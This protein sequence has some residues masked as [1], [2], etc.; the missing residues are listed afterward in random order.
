YERLFA[1]E[2]PGAAEDVK[3]ELNPS[4]L[5]TVAGF[6]EPGLRDAPAGKSLQFERLGYFAVDRQPGAD[7]RVVFN[8]TSGLKDSWGKS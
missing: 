7:G 2:Q 3:E 5:Q 4:S 6:I 1:A 8:R